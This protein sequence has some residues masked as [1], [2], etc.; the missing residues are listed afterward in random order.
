MNMDTGIHTDVT[1]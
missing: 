1:W